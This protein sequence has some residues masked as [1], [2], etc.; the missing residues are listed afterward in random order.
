MENAPPQIP[1]PNSSGYYSNFLS[2]HDEQNLICIIRKTTSNLLPLGE[3]SSGQIL[4]TILEAFAT[5]I[6]LPY[7]FSLPNHL[8]TVAGCKDFVHKTPQSIVLLADVYEKNAFSWLCEKVN[9]LLPPLPSKPREKAFVDILTD[10]IKIKVEEFKKWSETD[11]QKNG[12]LFTR[13]TPP[14]VQDLIALLCKRR[15]IR[16]GPELDRLA[17]SEKVI[18]VLFGCSDNAPQITE[19]EYIMYSHAKFLSRKLERAPFPHLKDS[20]LVCFMV[21]SIMDN[22]NFRK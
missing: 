18:Q 1:E 4:F 5:Q 11:I 14:H 15:P 20:T 13:D 2:L 7:P 19:E 8:Q 22:P 17:L 9:E 3:S 10:R 12:A 21:N 6:P 16:P